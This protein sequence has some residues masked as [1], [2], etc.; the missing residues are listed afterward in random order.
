MPK[1]T[2]RAGSAP[3]TFREMFDWCFYGEDGK[4]HEYTIENRGEQ[5]LSSGTSLIEQIDKGDHIQGLEDAK[6]ILTCLK[7]SGYHLTKRTAPIFNFG[8]AIFILFLDVDKME[9]L[10]QQK[11][12]YA[13]QLKKVFKVL[14]VSSILNLGTAFHAAKSALGRTEGAPTILKICILL[15]EQFLIGTKIGRF[16]DEPGSFDFMS[17]P[18][19]KEAPDPIKE[20]FKINA[21]TNDIT[22]RYCERWY[23]AIMNKILDAGGEEKALEKAHD[24]TGL[25]LLPV[26]ST[27]SGLIKYNKYFDTVVVDY[28]LDNPSV[29]ANFSALPHPYAV[30]NTRAQAASSE[31]MKWLYF[32]T[33]M[34]LYFKE[35]GKTI[36]D[37][38]KGTGLSAQ[39]QPDKLRPLNDFLKDLDTL[40][41]TFFGI[42]Q[43]VFV[44]HPNIHNAENQ[45][46]LHK[47]LAA[48]LEYC[49]D[50]NG[51]TEAAIPEDFG[52]IVYPEKLKIEHVI[53]GLNRLQQRATYGYNLDGTIKYV[54]ILI[55]E[56]NAK[57]PEI[58]KTP[59]TNF[60]SVLDFLSAELCGHK[61]SKTHTDF[62]RIFPR[63]A[64][65]ERFA[66]LGN[67]P[68]LPFFM[69]FFEEDADPVSI[70]ETLETDLF[71]LYAAGTGVG[72]DDGHKHTIP[73]ND[74]RDL[75]KA[76]DG[77]HIVDP[78]GISGFPPAM[79]GSGE[80][81][82]IKILGDH[83]QGPVSETI[84]D[85]MK[86]LA[87]TLCSR[88]HAINVVCLAIAHIRNKVL[89]GINKDT[90]F[91]VGQNLDTQTCIRFS[92]GL[93][94]SQLLFTLYKQMYGNGKP[95]ILSCCQGER[96]VQGGGGSQVSELGQRGGASVLLLKFQ[97]QNG[98][99]FG[100]STADGHS[101]IGVGVDQYLHRMLDGKNIMK[102]ILGGYAELDVGGGAPIQNGGDLKLS[103]YQKN[104]FPSLVVDCLTISGN[105]REKIVNPYPVMVFMLG[106]RPIPLKTNSA[107]TGPGQFPEQ[108][109]TNDR[110]L[111]EL[112]YMA[113]GHIEFS[114]ISIEQEDY[115]RDIIRFATSKFYY[116]QMKKVQPKFLDEMGILKSRLSA[117]QNSEDSEYVLP[118]D[119][120]QTITDTLKTIHSIG[121][122][123]F[124]LEIE[125]GELFSALGGDWL[126]LYESMLPENLRKN[127]ALQNFTGQP[128]TVEDLFIHILKKSSWYYNVCLT[129]IICVSIKYLDTKKNELMEECKLAM[130]KLTHAVN[131]SLSTEQIR[132]LSRQPSKKRRQEREAYSYMLRS[133]IKPCENIFL[134]K[135][136]KK[137]RNIDLQRFLLCKAESLITEGGEFGQHNTDISIIEMREICKMY[138]FSSV[139]IIEE[140]YK[141]NPSEDGKIHINI[142]R[143]FTG[144]YTVIL[145]NEISKLTKTLYENSSFYMTTIPGVFWNGNPN[146]N[147]HAKLLEKINNSAEPDLIAPIGYSHEPV[148]D[149]DDGPADHSDWEYSDSE[150]EPEEPMAE[151]GS[152]K[153]RKSIN[154]RKSPKTLKKR[155]KQVRKK[156]IKRNYKRNKKS[157]L[158][159]KK[160]NKKIKKTIRK[161]KNN[162]RMK[163]SK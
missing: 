159:N 20:G 9:K 47:G 2:P 19:I 83:K 66:A 158:K 46:P 125:T 122:L 49:P 141:L 107:D 99:G 23:I 94:L 136:K 68:T 127:I 30:Q 156:T 34:T 154:K 115:L 117:I 3:S 111:F 22:S 74:F 58:E 57:E 45:N 35:D 123:P 31:L 134:K 77:G 114:I 36:F 78:H 118:F 70:L 105:M 144:K 1:G 16:D 97:D 129:F 82:V 25:K 151:G 101:E 84:E 121:N 39:G 18:R 150:S 81:L 95:H 140:M 37:Y 52:I 130:K 15:E 102:N 92:I 54:D 88:A 93:G 10:R 6:N 21:P 80:N 110:F 155:R 11:L 64:T 113:Y 38:L 103:R 124:L 126:L 161:L 152:R 131:F 76:F 143:I 7:Y 62:S 153:R 137:K 160:P 73:E 85:I 145:E 26:P 40:P 71:E 89:T 29:N 17:V 65:T 32:I 128:H 41:T 109:L 90:L 112:F 69:S 43:S 138:G 53:A 14:T 4:G 56:F 98:K 87:P 12:L 163:K 24:E 100:R 8:F 119:T 27:R 106:C 91:V 72:I 63:P 48:H 50:A 13:D 146:S 149:D 139:I 55:T 104:E 133:S 28:F 44:F 148:T 157:V 42:A 116:N 61:I 79:I 51:G 162:K 142:G 96:S 60:K 135:L 147:I 132:D 108:F 67:L 59:P 75:F 86:K 120:I 33:N 5:M